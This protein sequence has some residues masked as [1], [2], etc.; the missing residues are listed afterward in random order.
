MISKQEVV[1]KIEALFEELS[2]QF[3]AIRERSEQPDLIEVELLEARSNY[4][5]QHIHIYRRLAE[6][7]E[8]LKQMEDGLSEDSGAADITVED[9]ETLEELPVN[10]YSE[11]PLEDNVDIK[12]EFET[13]FSDLNDGME[14]PEEEVED[15]EE[16]TKEP[17]EQA[18]K[19]E[20]G[21]S[22]FLREERNDE[23]GINTVERVSVERSF[24]E[25]EPERE[26]EGKL[27]SLEEQREEERVSD[28]P[29]AE[30]QHLRE[31]IS[32]EPREAKTEPGNEPRR[33]LSLNE[34]FSAQRKKQPDADVSPSSP[35][36]SS[37][38]GSHGR[39]ADL[40]S[41]ISLND[42]L[43][44]IKDL[45]NG[46]SLAYTEAMELLGRFTTFQEAD[47]FLQ[48]NYAVK[49]NWASKQATVDKLYIILQKRFS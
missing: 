43:L 31:E 34:L 8:S 2:A 32:E 17:E 1:A 25:P 12:P 22:F 14:D 23:E 45:F 42:K 6:T 9:H 48:S 3:A 47:H 15:P 11:S 35:T 27:M 29:A 33:P 13:D 7:S 26:S 18:A 46:Y 36:M 16:K 40:K 4:L 39:K 20:Y 28:K 19:P 30:E 49:N 24:F 21:S 10:E 38:S 5:N 44:F 37:T 41:S